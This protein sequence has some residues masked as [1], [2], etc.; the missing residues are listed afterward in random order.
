MARSDKRQVLGEIT[1]NIGDSERG[2]RSIYG[3]DICDVPYV[4][5]VLV[6]LHIIIALNSSEWIIYGFLL[7]ELARR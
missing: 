1:S 6:G 4:E 7:V 2:K 5:M 3:C